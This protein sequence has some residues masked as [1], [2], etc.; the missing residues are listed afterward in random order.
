MTNISLN[1]YA[2]SKTVFI[3]TI[4]AILAVCIATGSV[5]YQLK[6]IE[7]PTPTPSP[8]QNPTPTPQPTDDPHISPIEKIIIQS[9]GYDISHKIITVYAQSTGEAIPV[10]NSLIVKDQ[11][12]NTIATLEIGTIS[13]TATGNALAKGTLY[14][15]PSTIYSTGLASGTYTA[16]LVTNA[17][18]SFV[19]PSFTVTNNPQSYVL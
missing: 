10:V 13:P 7:T 1:S 11:S 6:P 12:G 19:S 5:A 3:L 14:T 18:G 2:V 17:G 8:T 9:V 16:T 4:V 15:L